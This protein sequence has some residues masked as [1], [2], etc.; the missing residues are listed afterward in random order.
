MEIR[1]AD[2][3]LGYLTLLVPYAHKVPISIYLRL[4]DTLKPKAATSAVARKTW[5]ELFNPKDLMARVVVAA[6]NH[7]LSR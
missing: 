1:F 7:R 6:T 2:P 3:Y 5:K 4:E